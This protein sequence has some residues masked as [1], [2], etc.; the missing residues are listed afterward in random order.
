MAARMAVFLN[1]RS[2]SAPEREKLVRALDSARLRADVHDICDP[3]VGRSLEA[4][5]SA[6]HMLIAAGGDGT[7][8]AVASVAA[9]TKKTLAVIP[10]GTANHFA[11][12]AGVPL[13]LDAAIELIT[14]GAK[15]RIDV[16]VVNGRVF[17][18][19]A[20][21]GVYPR[22]VWERHKVRQRGVPR[23][24]ASTLA[25]IDT[26]LELR[27]VTATLS[28]DDHELVRRTPIVV[29]GN[30]E[31]E[32]EGMRLG[33]RRTLNGGRLSLYVAPGLGRAD[34]IAMPIRAMLGRLKSHEKFEVWT[35]ASIGVRTAHLHVG[36]AIDGEIVRLDMPLQFRLKH[37]ALEAVLPDAEAA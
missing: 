11:R 27:N 17:L 14:S 35:A 37:D 31:Y 13:D 15:R 4:V 9:A 16:G 2:G 26:W 10:A 6:Y 36:V 34:A 1:P 19:N 25:V 3:R 23:P 24:F 28:I 30:G 29:V 7:V 8:S 20:S 33:K 18:N 32:V 22:M 12:D 5:S 21:L